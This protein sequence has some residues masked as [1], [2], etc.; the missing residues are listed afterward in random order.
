MSDIESLESL[1]SEYEKE[2]TLFRTAMIQYETEQTDESRENFEVHQARM[3]GVFDRLQTMYTNTLIKQ[4]DIDQTITTQLQT[5]QQ[6]I[7]DYQHLEKTASSS[8]DSMLAAYPMYDESIFRTRLL[9]LHLVLVVAGSIG[10][11]VMM[12]IHSRTKPNTKPTAVNKNIQNIRQN[13]VK[14]IKQT[15][16]IVQNQATQYGQKALNLADNAVVQGQKQ[17]AKVYNQALNLM[18]GKPPTKPNKPNP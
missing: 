18:F 13:A 8:L 5:N 1:K 6:D 4:Q 16:N 12:M 2:K 3:R 7:Q 9:Y 10:V 17:G 14:N 11:L 15:Q